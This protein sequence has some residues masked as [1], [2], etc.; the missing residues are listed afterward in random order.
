MSF[1]SFVGGRHIWSLILHSDFHYHL[2]LNLFPN[3]ER[4]VSIGSQCA[5]LLTC[6]DCFVHYVYFQQTRI[7]SKITLHRTITLHRALKFYHR[8]CYSWVLKYQSFTFISW[9]DFE[10][11]RDDIWNVMKCSKLYEKDKCWKSCTDL[12]GWVVSTHF[13]NKWKWEGIE[14]YLI[15][16]FSWIYAA[17]KVWEELQM[18][19]WPYSR[20][21][22]LSG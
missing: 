15:T 17:V 1:A 14:N 21:C 16:S 22:C 11:I 8:S 10:P 7:A 9:T 13:R 5:L 20:G 12:H 18:I 4:P 2:H 19:S 6:W 3:S